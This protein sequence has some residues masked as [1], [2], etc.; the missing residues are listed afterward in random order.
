M[1]VNFP[2]KKCTP[3]VALQE[4]TQVGYELISNNINILKKTRSTCTMY[5]GD[6]TWDKSMI[7]IINEIKNIAK[8]DVDPNLIE[9]WS[10]D[11]STK[12]GDF[13][14]VTAPGPKTVIDNWS[15][16]GFQNMM[17]HIF[18]GKAMPG[19]CDVN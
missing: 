10:A 8:P 4:A 7:D 19:T 16:T 2:I 3:L 15:Q 9:I 14:V 18:N 6:K 17:D 13:F 12:Y 1:Y 11:G 5:T